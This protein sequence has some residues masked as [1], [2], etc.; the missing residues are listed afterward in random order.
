MQEPRDFGFNSKET[1]AFVLDST[2]PP[3]FTQHWSRWRD[4]VWAEPAALEP[5]A[6]SGLTQH[7][8]THV[9]RSLGGVYVG[10]RLS[11]AAPGAARG[12]VITSHGYGVPDQPM[13]D[14]DPWTV[15]DGMA[16]IKIRLRGFPGSDGVTGDLTGAPFGHICAGLDSSEP[17]LD[18]SISGSTADLLNVFRAAR[19]MYGRNVPIAIHG[20]SYGGG[21]AVLAA[22]QV[23][24]TDNVHRMALGVPTLGGWHW[25]M[26]QRVTSGS[27]Y[28]MARF[29]EAHPQ[30]RDR[31]R[32]LLRQFD[33]VVHARRVVCPVVCKLALKDE[34]VPAPTAAAIF[35]ALGSDPGRKWRF[36]TAFGH[37]DGGVEDLRRHVQYEGLIGEF[38]D[39]AKRPREMMG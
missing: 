5:T 12:V 23:F 24:G 22:S 21:I 38:L 35:N 27:G 19:L 17:E 11:G 6:S 29:I 25:R 31:T 16:V 28:D 4:L 20:E 3:G 2:P 39:P 37:F 15:R 14:R 34:V 10:C 8:V 7:G 13:D 36:V 26:E 33:A 1:L 9:V 32:E 18:W 30:L